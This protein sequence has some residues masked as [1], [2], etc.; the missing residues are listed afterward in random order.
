MSSGGGGNKGGSSSAD[1]K[2]LAAVYKILLEMKKDPECAL[3]LRPVVEEYPDLKEDYLMQIQ[4]P[5]DFSTVEKN[6][7]NKTCVA[8]AWRGLAWRGGVRTCARQL[9]RQQRRRLR[10]GRRQ[11]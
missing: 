7:K 11:Q 6:Y 1:A 8:Q 9:Q 10:R 4:K 2:G 3:F 5:M